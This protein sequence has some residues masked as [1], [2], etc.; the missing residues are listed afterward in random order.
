M[1]FCEN[2]S[3][4]PW[5]SLPQHRPLGAVNRVRRTVYESVSKKRHAL[6]QTPRKEPTGDEAF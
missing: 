5:H 3:F 2:L 4:T 1:A 6:N